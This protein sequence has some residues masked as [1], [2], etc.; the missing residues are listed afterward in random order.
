[1]YDPHADV[2]VAFRVRYARMTRDLIGKIAAVAYENG[3]RGC[4]IIEVREGRNFYS[5]YY[6]A[7]SRKGW[8]K[9]M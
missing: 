9:E 4:L 6:D 1:M 5:G 8:L 7:R 3:T 2:R